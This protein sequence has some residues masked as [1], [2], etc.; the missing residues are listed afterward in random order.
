MKSNG[1]GTL[2]NK[3]TSE[4]SFSSVYQDEGQVSSTYKKSIT[5]NSHLLMS[6]KVENL[7]KVKHPKFS[8]FLILLGLLLVKNIVVKPFH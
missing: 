6:V 4:T 1:E 8:F 2:N 5:P 3:S 7:E